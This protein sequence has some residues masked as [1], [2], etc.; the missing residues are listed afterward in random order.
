M[1]AAAQ[2][3]LVADIGGTNA[4]FALV[5]KGRCGV[6]HNYAVAGFP[7]AADAIKVF[8]AKAGLPRPP[9]EAVLAIAGPVEAGRGCLTNGA[10]EFDSETLE[11]ELG[12]S[13]I[14]LVNDFAAVANSLPF[15]AAEDLYS[16]GGGKAVTG[17]PSV[18]LGPGTGLG[19]AAF[20]P[21][22][23]GIVL[24]TEGGHATLPAEDEREVEILA[25]LR[26]RFGHVSA[27]RVLSGPGLEA[28]YE[29]L[30]FIDGREPTPT[31]D[32]D[33][34]TAR[35][36]GG[37]C[38]ASVATLKTFCAMLGGF[39]GNVALTMGAHG[40][41]YL[42]GGI[43][44]RFPEFLAKS[45]FRDRFEAKGRFHDWLASVPTFVVTHTDP[46][47]PGLVAL[48]NESA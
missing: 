36:L 41:V 25:F 33:E 44:P 32:A 10:W 11:R 34:I 45:E 15:F 22:N 26:D 7:A 1:R 47:F 37:Q 40:G 12:I 31:P 8:L 21:V 17:S 48:L 14:H 4:R 27:E 42:A 6:I 3:G 43:L 28:L 30:R 23:G 46:A 13:H 35:A 19:V 16:I 39:A 38:A 2:S 24:P 20:V 29:A 18:V 5:D 9:Q